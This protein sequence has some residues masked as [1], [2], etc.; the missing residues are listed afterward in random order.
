MAAAAAQ[1]ETPGRRA[2]NGGQLGWSALSKPRDDEPT[3]PLADAVAQQQAT[4]NTLL[5]RIRNT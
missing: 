2:S 5:S 1:L 3:T 4:S